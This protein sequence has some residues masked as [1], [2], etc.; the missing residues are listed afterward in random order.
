MHGQGRVRTFIVRDDKAGRANRAL[1]FALVLVVSAF[2]AAVLPPRV[3]AHGE[4]DGPAPHALDVT[5]AFPD[6]GLAVGELLC[7]ALFAGH[8]GDFTAP[9]QS[10]C[11]GPGAAGVRFDGLTHGPYTLVVLAPGSAIQGNRYQGQVIATDV[12][13]EPDRSDY[14]LPVALKLAPEVAGT[15]G[16][17]Q[18]SVFGCPP[19]TNAGGDADGWLNQCDTLANDVPVSLS[20]IGSIEDTIDQAVTGRDTA[21]PGR[22]EFANLPPGDYLLDE[23]LPAD[24]R[25]A[26]VFVESSIDGSITPLDPD[27]PTLA[28]RPAEVKSVAYFV[29]LD[30]AEADAP[31]EAAPAGDPALAGA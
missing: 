27:D 12:P 31:A 14:G 6:A 15:T 7:L 13:D 25:D 4:A 22:V 3:R 16:R 1:G 18:V 11:L 8:G 2:L 28:L 19:G 9:V 5:V 30:A 10:D 23:T 26:A 29:V 21:Q 20:G 17:V 24:A